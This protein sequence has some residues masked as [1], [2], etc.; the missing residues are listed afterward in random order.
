MAS[1]IGPQ[2]LREL[3]EIEASVFGVSRKRSHVDVF[4][5][6]NGG[7]LLERVFGDVEWRNFEDE[8]RCTDVDDVM[9]Y[10]TT[11][12][13]GEDATLEEQRQ[14]R[15]EVENRVRKGEGVPHVTKDSR[16]FLARRTR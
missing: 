2:H 6:S 14:L 13:P 16:V 10:L 5:S 7:A 8:L 3:F 9:A 15:V 12:P 11:T 4:G 1:T